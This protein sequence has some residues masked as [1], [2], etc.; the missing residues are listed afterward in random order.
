MECNGA[1]GGDGQWRYSHS[2]ANRGRW[3]GENN[4]YFYT[5]SINPITQFIK[6]TVELLE[7][8]GKKKRKDFKFLYRTWVMLQLSTSHDNKKHPSIIQAA[9]H[10][11]VSCSC[12]AYVMS[13]LTVNGFHIRRDYGSTINGNWGS[14]SRGPPRMKTLIFCLGI[15]G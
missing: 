1:C 2:P 9:S 6:N 3:S 12:A 5:P 4:K 15:L 14:C 7:S 11:S 13:T 8:E 10:S